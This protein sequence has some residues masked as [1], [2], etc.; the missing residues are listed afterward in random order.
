MSGTMA[1]DVKNEVMNDAEHVSIHKGSNDGAVPGLSPDEQALGLKLR[2]KIDIVIM[3]TIMVVYLLNWI[4][5]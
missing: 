3:P 2:K 1:D 4:D 5:R